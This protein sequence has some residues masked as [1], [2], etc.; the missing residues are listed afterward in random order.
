M[1]GFGS[2]RWAWTSTRET[3]DGVISLD[4]RTLARTGVLRPGTTSETRWSRRG[5]P[6]GWISLTA[7]VNAVV[8]SY[9]SRRLGGEWEPVE[10]RIALDRTAC[11]FGGERSW[12]ICPGCGRR[13]AVLYSPNGRFR[14]RVC[15]DL[16]YES[17]REKPGDRAQRR[18]DKLWIRLGGDMYKGRGWRSLP[19]KPKGM[20]WT[21]FHR[22]QH[23]LLEA[24]HDALAAWVAD[25]D[26][27]IARLDRKFGRPE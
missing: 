27:L 11:Q 17:T 21:T 10:E 1:G 4:I 20:R 26:A 7:R 3:T 5:E 8:L 2:G 13:R 24:E 12:F 6:F 25:S 22:L 15:H 14:C 19:T 9:R 23:Q 16:A 18:A